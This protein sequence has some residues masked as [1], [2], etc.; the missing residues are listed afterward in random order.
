[1]NRF[2]AA[3]TAGVASILAL[4]FAAASAQPMRAVPPASS[5]ASAAVRTEEGVRWRD[6]TPNQ[7]QA[8]APLE[9]EWAAIDAQRKQKWLALAGRIH[10]LDPAAR[11]RIN[12]RMSE[13]ARLSP[14]ERGQARMRFEEARQVPGADRRERWR[15]YQ[16]L[17]AEAKQ[18]L[19]AR[20]ASAAASSR[21]DVARREAAVARTRNGRDSREAKVNIVPNAAP[22]R[23]PREVAPTLMQAG[24]GATTTLITRR[25]M[26]PVHQRTGMPKIAATPEF[27]DRS[28]LLPRRGP[29]AP[30]P[31][32]AAASASASASA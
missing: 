11:A 16:A 7:R 1:M 30:M 21:A 6:L 29:Q 4:F 17:S 9:H 25:P 19:A 28:T 13:W 31:V 26:P 18:L 27:I 24:P 22:A 2:A 3:R 23:P 5:P 15:D 10:G 32:R 14:V 12:D 8:L 20:A